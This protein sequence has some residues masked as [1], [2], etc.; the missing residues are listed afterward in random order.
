MTS[1]RARRVATTHSGSNEALSTSARDMAAMASVARLLV[2]RAL[3]LEVSAPPWSTNDT[4]PGRRSG[5][6]ARDRARDRR[7]GSATGTGD[8]ADRGRV[9]TAG[10]ATSPRAPTGT[11]GPTRSATARADPRARRPPRGTNDGSG[12]PGPRTGVG[13]GF[14]G[15]AEHELA[16]DVALDLRRAGID[17]AGPGIEERAG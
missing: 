4:I 3:G 10:G 17:G 2:V 6:R 11:F 1:T 5:Q 14:L 7:T 13:P 9:A 8:T 16:D 12:R 15:Q